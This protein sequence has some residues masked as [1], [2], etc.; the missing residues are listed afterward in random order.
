MYHDYVVKKLVHRGLSNSDGLLE[1]AC[2][3]RA[4]FQFLIPSRRVHV[5]TCST[6][7]VSQTT[8]VWFQTASVPQ[9]TVRKMVLAGK[10]SVYETKYLRKNV[11]QGTMLHQSV[12]KRPHTAFFKSPFRCTRSG[13][14]NRVLTGQFTSTRNLSNGI[15]GGLAPKHMMRMLCKD[16][17]AAE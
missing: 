5:Q 14:M 12:R 11:P 13:L 15:P 7:G 2:A 8:L 17:K 16:D 9:K 10:C 1:L 3:I 6:I 4:A